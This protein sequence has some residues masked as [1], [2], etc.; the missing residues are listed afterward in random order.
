MLIEKNSSWRFYSEPINFD[1]SD[2]IEEIIAYKAE[3]DID[4][5]RQNLTDIHKDSKMFQIKFMSYF[6]SLGDKVFV[7]DV[8]SL[9]NEN[10]KKC[11]YKLFDIFEKHYDGKVVRCEVIGLLPGGSVAVH[12]DDGDFAKYARRI[13]VPIL[14]NNNVFFTVMDE[15]IN[16]KLGNWYEIN[17]VLDHSVK[18][19]SDEKRIHIIIDV[20]EKR[21]LNE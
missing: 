8:N 2:L 11:L 13:H 5:S 10:S 19:E 21:Y 3:W 17:N 4:T 6:W 7:Q 20:L 1:I 16:M 12:Q 15:T 18:N 9:K 14:T